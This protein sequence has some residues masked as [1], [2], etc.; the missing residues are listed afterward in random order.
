MGARRKGQEYGWR[1]PVDNTLNIQRE[2][3]QR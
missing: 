1:L 2:T 3:G